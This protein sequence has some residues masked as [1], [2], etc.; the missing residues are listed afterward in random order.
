M[1]GLSSLIILRRLMAAVDPDPPP[2]PCDAKHTRRSPGR[3]FRDAIRAIFSIARRDANEVL[4]RRIARWAEEGR[5]KRKPPLLGVIR[6]QR[7]TNA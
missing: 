1:R 5:R 4:R 2:K 3:S 7:A 6:S